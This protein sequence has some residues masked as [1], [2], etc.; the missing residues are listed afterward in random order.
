MKPEVH[1]G[2]SPACC[3]LGPEV[4]SWYTLT[5]RLV[6]CIFYIFYPVFLSVVRGIEGFFFPELEVLGKFSNGGF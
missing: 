6:L 5:F 2:N 1:P 4:T 3:S